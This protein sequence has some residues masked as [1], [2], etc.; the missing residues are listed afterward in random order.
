M[1][2]KISVEDKI[3]IELALDDI[4]NVVNNYIGSSEST[5]KPMLIWFESNEDIDKARRTIRNILGC[6][7]VNQHPLYG[8]EHFIDKD[9]KVKKISDH[10]ELTNG[11]IYPG[12]YD[13]NV[14]FFL[15]HRY[16]EQLYDGHIAYVKELAEKTQKP[17]LLLVNEYSNEENPKFDASSFEEYT[18]LN[19]ME[20]SNNIEKQKNSAL[21][22]EARKL[23]LLIQCGN[24]GAETRLLDIYKGYTSSMIRQYKGKG[25]TDEEIT[26]ACESALIRAAR[27]F[28]LDKDFAFISYAIW[29]MKEGVL[30]ARKAKR[31]EKINQIFT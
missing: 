22:T 11:F 29:W 31:M 19:K 9:G 12:R 18:I 17:L 23:V 20:N 4:V 1:N 7:E 8:H 28:D 10:P 24:A 14:R 25:L 16:T 13:E 21:D 26:S 6:C 2:T 27:K 15:Y 30:Q 3:H 5:K